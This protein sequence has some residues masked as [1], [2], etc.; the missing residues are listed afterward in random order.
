MWGLVLGLVEHHALPPLLHND[1][2][3][4]RVRWDRFTRK[5]DDIRSP[6]RRR[7]KLLKP[8]ID[9]SLH[10]IPRHSALHRAS[11]SSIVA[12]GRGIRA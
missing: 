11:H 4:A 3:F 6:V 7:L 10:S 1:N 9:V 5:D 2:Q 8:S 12:Q